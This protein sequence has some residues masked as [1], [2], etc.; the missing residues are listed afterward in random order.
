MSSSTQDLN[1]NLQK[2]IPLIDDLKQ[3]ITNNDF[4]EPLDEKLLFVMKKLSS[5][6]PFNN[7]I[8]DMYAESYRL[9]NNK[10]DLLD[11]MK[12]NMILLKLD[13]WKEKIAD[14]IDTIDL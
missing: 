12:K 7:I 10:R 14:S 3:R 9:K 8:I 5:L 11:P 2:L 4:S 1:Q 6:N 13:F